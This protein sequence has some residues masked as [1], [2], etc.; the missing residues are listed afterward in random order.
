MNNPHQ[1]ARMTLH[2]R[3]QIVAPVLAG[4]NAA[5]VAALLNCAGAPARVSGQ[6]TEATVAL[7]VYLRR[8]LRMTGATIV[9]KLWLARSTVVRWLR[10]EGLERLAQIDP[11]APVRR[12]Q[13]D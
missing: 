12:Y 5:E 2:S 6:L 4:Q 9:A 8:G 7:M 10:R 13:H 3:E 11:P 1:N